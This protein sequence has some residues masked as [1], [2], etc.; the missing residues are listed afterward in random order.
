[1][2][3]WYR[4]AEVCYAYL[5]DATDEKSV[6]RSRWFTRGWTLPE[7]IAPM[8]LQFYTS[9]WTCLG[10]KLEYA[11]HIETAT[12]IDREVLLTGHFGQVSIAKRMAVSNSWCHFFPVPV[13]SRAKPPP[14]WA[15]IMPQGFVCP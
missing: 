6:T 4:N 1:M 10:S 15:K 7:L 13:K 14:I 2:F 11:N 12:G 9:D 5:V 8:N 3:R